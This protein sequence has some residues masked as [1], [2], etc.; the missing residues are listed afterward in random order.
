MLLGAANEANMP[1]LFKLELQVPCQYTYRYTNG[2]EIKQNLQTGT[3]GTMSA[4]NGVC[5]LTVC[6]ALRSRHARNWLRR[7]FARKL[8]GGAIISSLRSLIG[9]ICL[10]QRELGAGEAVPAQ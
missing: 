8:A 1:G 7:L 9:R 4:W 10:S 3:P 2:C 5:L 6:H